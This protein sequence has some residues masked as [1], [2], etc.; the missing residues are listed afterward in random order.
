MSL[1]MRSRANYERW[2]MIAISIASTACHKSHVNGST[3]PREQPCLGNWT[4][5]VTNNTD[6]VYDLYVGTRLVGSA[7]AHATTRAIIDP[8]LGQ[9]TPILRESATT[10]DIK[11]PR[12]ASNAVRM[13]CE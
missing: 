2:L 1:S 13:V 4:A 5:V 12:I 6:R 7:D 3:L 9:V 10:R 11:G 8:A